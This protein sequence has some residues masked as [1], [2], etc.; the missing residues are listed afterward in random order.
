MFTKTPGLGMP[1]LKNSK[2]CA[3]VAVLVGVAA[4]SAA[5]YIMNAYE[6]E[7]V[8][9]CAGNC[10]PI[11]FEE[12]ELGMCGCDADDPERLSLEPDPV[13]GP[14][15]S[16]EDGCRKHLDMSR[17]ALVIVSPVTTGG[18]PATAS[19]TDDPVPPDAYTTWNSCWYNLAERNAAGCNLKRQCNVEITKDCQPICTKT[20]HEEQGG[21]SPDGSTGCHNYC[22]QTCR[23]VVEKDNPFRSG[24]LGGML[25][26]MEKLSN[27]FDWDLPDSVKY[28]L[29]AVLGLFLLGGAGAL[30]KGAMGK[31]KGG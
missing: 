24:P 9:N 22:L 2:L 3:G 16:L 26:V 18:G 21:S 30:L 7:A 25:K 14:G 5:I 19:P 10:L 11:R 20:T 13:R 12:Y 29:V 23:S 17:R 31:K 8:R 6:E 27:P 15:H 4:I 28:T 1:C